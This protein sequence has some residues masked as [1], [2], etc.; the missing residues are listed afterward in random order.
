[1]T[2]T[3]VCSHAR[4]GFSG[5]HVKGRLKR[6]RGNG[7]ART[8]KYRIKDQSIHAKHSP[9]AEKPYGRVPRSSR[10]NE[11]LA[12]QVTPAIQQRLDSWPWPSFSFLSPFRR[13]G[14]SMLPPRLGRRNEHGERGSRDMQ[15]QKWVHAIYPDTYFDD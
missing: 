10:Y 7:H 6:S 14:S 8:R 11:S 15:F 9:A 13:T 5:V 3:G 4:I 12:G 2:C 1:M